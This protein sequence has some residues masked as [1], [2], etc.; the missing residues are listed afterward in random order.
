MTTGIVY[1]TTVNT[2]GTVNKST[3]SK[4]Y[5]GTSSVCVMS[6]E[7]ETVYTALTNT[8]ESTR[9]LIGD[10]SQYTYEEGWTDIQNTVQQ[11]TK[12]GLQIFAAVERDLNMKG[13]Y[14]HISY[15]YR[16]HYSS[17]L[18]DRY[19]YKAIQN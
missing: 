4:S 9:Y 19:V 14:L 18:L 13:Y 12:P 17:E 10:I 6:W 5:T 7:L 16:N 11:T 8:T 2:S 3:C 1:G 15:C